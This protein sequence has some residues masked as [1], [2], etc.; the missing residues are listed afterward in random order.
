MRV[1]KRIVPES[2]SDY[3]PSNQ[4]YCRSG[5][6]GLR[7]GDGGALWPMLWLSAARSLWYRSSSPD[8]TEPQVSCECHNGWQPG[9]SLPPSERTCRRYEPWSIF[10]DWAQLFGWAE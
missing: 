1:W 8:S 2:A 3:S 9:I 6:F 5:Y 10:L 4:L 7:F